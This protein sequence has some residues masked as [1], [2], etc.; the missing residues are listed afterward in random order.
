M[1]YWMTAMRSILTNPVNLLCCLL[2]ALPAVAKQTDYQEKIYVD[3][4]RQ[5][6]ELGQNKV[7]F[8]DEVVITQGT[9][10]ITADKVEVMRKGEKGAEEM[11]AYGSPATFF[12]ILDNGKPVNARAKQL[13]YK[14]SEKL[15]IL[16][17]QA[18]LQQ[19]D[20]KVTSDVIR[21]DIQK[22][23]MTAETTSKSS[24]VKT[25]FMPEQM[26]DQGQE[27]KKGGQ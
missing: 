11:I 22:Q 12:Q 17:D 18:E 21:Y 26:H 8:L 15:V 13:H 16:T 20:N 24:R 3:S 10:K 6:A 9:I 5:L 2:L 14:L 1:N 4:N 7:S 23:Q 27:P 25:V 19:E